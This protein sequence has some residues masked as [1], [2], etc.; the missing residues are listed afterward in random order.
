MSIVELRNVLASDSAVSVFG[1][2]GT[3]VTSSRTSP[4]PFAAYSTC[5]LEVHPPMAQ[6][7]NALTFLRYTC[8]RRGDRFR[9][10]D[11]SMPLRKQNSVLNAHL[12][13]SCE[14]VNARNLKGQQCSFTLLMRLP[15][16]NRIDTFPCGAPYQP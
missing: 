12:S 4:C 8:P 14:W 5:S 10:D 7:V 11:G 1:Y 15:D 6:R 16:S 9:L 13:L 3:E 2:A